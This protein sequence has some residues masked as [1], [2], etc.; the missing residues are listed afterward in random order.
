VADG[1]PGTDDAALAAAA[2][3]ALHDEELV[4]AYAADGL[5]SDDEAAQ[6]ASLVAR[7]TVCRDLHRDIAAIGAALGAEARF[8]AAA[9]PRDFRLTVDDAVRLGGHVRRRGLGASLNRTLLA[10]ARPVGAT[11]AT[12]GLVG[13]LVGTASFGGAA[14]LPLAGPTRAGATSAPA[15]ITAGGTQPDGPK[16]SGDTA[17]GSLDSRGTGQSE[18]EP[19]TDRDLTEAGW[20]PQV[21]LLGS[22]VAMLL[23]GV[24]LLG[25]SFRRGRG[26]AAR[27]QAPGGH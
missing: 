14:S 1:Q 13:V 21:W 19:P 12:F 25:V 22:S 7:C 8:T 24:L 9:A 23:A 17:F 10:F 18:G 16:A 27:S 2:R 3:H 11:L 15:E 6:A 26:G 5:E 4:A 20:S